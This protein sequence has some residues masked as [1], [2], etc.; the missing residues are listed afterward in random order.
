MIRISSECRYK[1]GHEQQGQDD[2]PAGELKLGRDA[3][4]ELVGVPVF[5]VM[6]RVIEAS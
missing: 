6:P 4:A 1:D 5:H 2:E 3:A